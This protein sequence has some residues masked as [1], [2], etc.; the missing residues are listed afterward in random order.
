MT[1]KSGYAKVGVVYTLME[2]FK[3]AM[4]MAIPECRSRLAWLSC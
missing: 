3:Q 1:E 2:P 4:I